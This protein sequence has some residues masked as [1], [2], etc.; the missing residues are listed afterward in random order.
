MSQL[1][2]WQIDTIQPS[3]GC[4]CGSLTMR[5][6]D[7]SLLRYEVDT[8]L[9]S[10][11]PL[12]LK[13][14]ARHD[15]RTDRVVAFIT[16]WLKKSATPKALFGGPIRFIA[17]GSSVRRSVHASLHGR[18]INLAFGQMGQLFVGFAFLIQRFLQQ[19]GG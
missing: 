7:Y 4:Q 5:R 12:C 1:S 9:D 16:T 19:S 17:T 3:G 11:D 6:L 2:G 15:H 10:A 13:E 18:R 14:N 8:C